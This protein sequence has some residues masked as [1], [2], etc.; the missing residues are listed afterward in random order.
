MKNFKRAI[1]LIIVF[2]LLFSLTGC[3]DTSEMFAKHSKGKA[4]ENKNYTPVEDININIPYISNDS[5][6]PY[7]AKSETNHKLATLIY[8]SLYTVGNDFQPIPLIAQSYKTEGNSLVVTIKNGLTFSDGSPLTV[9]DVVYS[10]N[11]A[12]N[13]DAYSDDLSNLDRA[14]ATNTNDVTFTFR[15]FEVDLVNLLTFP[16]IKGQGSEDD[17]GYYYNSNDSES[18]FKIPAGS[19]RYF[20]TK[21]KHNS[22]YLCC[23]TQRLGGYFPKHRNIGL[24]GT[25]E[26]DKIDPM[27]SLGRINFI[28]ET[29]EDG[30]Y[31]QIIGK[32]VRYSLPNFVYLVCNVTD[33]ILNNAEI[34]KAIS[35]ALDRKELSDFCFIGNALPT[36][37][38]F[39]PDYYKTTKITNEDKTY[40]DAIKQLESIG[41]TQVN[42]VYNFR[43]NP[44]NPSAVL[45]FSLAVCSDNEFK[46]IAAEKIKEQLG[47]ANIRVNIFEY[48]E[49]DF[50]KVLSSNAYDMYIGEC[51]LK[52]NLNLTRFFTVG[53]TLSY[54]INSYSDSAVAYLSYQNGNT[55]IGLFVNTFR[56]DLPFIPLLYR[57]GNI[58]SNQAIKTADEAIVTDF[59][60]NADKWTNVND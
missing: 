18:V 7:A 39:H 16:I 47:K 58:F 28:S 43:Y 3:F 8:D 6:N 44:E 20:L 26:E 11:K 41:Y 32:A 56:D 14:D 33:P 12:K 25:A 42:N 36:E 10:F 30:Q 52:N 27:Y 38:P 1:S 4:A 22:Y 24:V 53:S 48:S 55:D 46:L 21:D 45:E 59:Y 51:K 19:G 13:C 35:Y 5:L 31:R 15:T 57:T 34:K 29:Y 49:E 54:G 9:S 23:N 17:L 37:L 2:S 40:V 50:F 60:Y